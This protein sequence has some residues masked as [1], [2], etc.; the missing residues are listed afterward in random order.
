MPES[1]QTPATQQSAEQ[2]GDAT[3][4]PANFVRNLTPSHSY[5]V[6]ET[7]TVAASTLGVLGRL[8]EKEKLKACIIDI[9]KTRP[10]S[11]DLNGHVRSDLLEH[12]LHR[13]PV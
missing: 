3:T 2:N 5:F 1:A 6:C 7:G 10:P 12:Q 8:K 13:G 9:L 4:A 11:P